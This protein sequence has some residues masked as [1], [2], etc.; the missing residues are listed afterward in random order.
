[1]H[2]GLIV[3]VPFV[4]PATQRTLFDVALDELADGDPVNE[5][6]EVQLKDDAIEIARYEWPAAVD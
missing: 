4:P 5:A 6:W 1:M 3:I 2:A